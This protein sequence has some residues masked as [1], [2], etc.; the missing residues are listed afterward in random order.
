ML[1]TDVEIAKFMQENL[2]VAAVCDILD[3][4]GYRRSFISYGQ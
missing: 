2:H 1:S 4:L 3:S